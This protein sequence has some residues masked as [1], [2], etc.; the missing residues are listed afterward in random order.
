MASLSTEDQYDDVVAEL[1]RMQT[2]DKYCIGL[3]SRIWVW[4]S[5]QQL[6]DFRWASG[7]PNDVEAACVSVYNEV[8]LS[9][10]EDTDCDDTLPFVCQ[11]GAC[12][13]TIMYV[14]VHIV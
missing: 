4:N 9:E 14:Y 13:C 2:T 8:G 7:R 6:T 1:L 11:T 10:W 3:S 12:T 5:G